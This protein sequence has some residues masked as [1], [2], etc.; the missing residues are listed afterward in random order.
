MQKEFTGGLLI[1]VHK[2]CSYSFVVGS[3]VGVY[4]RVQK[5]YRSI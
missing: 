2:R 4:S 5:F 1:G 3:F